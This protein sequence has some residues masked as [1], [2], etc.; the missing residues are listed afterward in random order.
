MGGVGLRYL[1]ARVARDGVP[2]VHKHSCNDLDFLGRPEP[3]TRQL[4][5]PTTGHSSAQG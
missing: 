4:P 2:L 5:L 1:H 3:L